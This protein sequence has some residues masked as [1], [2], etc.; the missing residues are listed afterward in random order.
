M[1]SFDALDSDVQKNIA[2]F[3]IE[4]FLHE[5]SEQLGSPDSWQVAVVAQAIAAY[6]SGHFDLALAYISVADKHPH[7]RPHLK[8]FAEEV[9]QLT[10]RDLWARLV[11]PA[12]DGLLAE[13]IASASTRRPQRAVTVE[14]T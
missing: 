9:D 7:Q 14:T 6:Q 5:L 3:T 12:A 8:V 2:R 10:L 13:P 1:S 11:H 4:L